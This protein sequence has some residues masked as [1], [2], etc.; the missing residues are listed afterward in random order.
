MGALWLL[1]YPSSGLV[2]NHHID[3]H[4][5]RTLWD[6]ITNPIDPAERVKQ[7]GGNLLLFVPMGI[8]APLRW[9]RLDHYGRLLAAA[10]LTSAI[11]E[12]LQY[13]LGG[14]VASIGDVMLNTAGAALGYGALRVSRAVRRRS[15]QSMR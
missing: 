14:R 12:G 6:E 3:A 2:G 11:I 7:V 15:R 5:F 9:P 4:P 13:L 8:L 1:L 10:A